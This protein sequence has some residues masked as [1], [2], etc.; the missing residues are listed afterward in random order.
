MNPEVDPYFKAAGRWRAELV[1]LREIVLACKLSEELKWGSPCYVFEKSN[2]LIM[3]ELKE[4]CTLSFF[5]G[6]LLKDPEGILDKPGENTRAARVLR[7]TSVGEIDELESILKAYIREAIELEKAGA[8]VDF[9][10]AAELPV[11]DEL[12]MQFDEDPDFKKAFE[13]L[14]PGRQRAYL[15]HFGAAKQAKTRAS[16]VAASKR[17]IFAGKGMNDCICGMSKRMPGCDGSHKDLKNFKMW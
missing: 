2:V 5:K 16:R 6:A 15:L 8:K 13:A 7:F 17:R 12:Q 3:G 11:P 9:K 10:E 4:S 14:T 1:R